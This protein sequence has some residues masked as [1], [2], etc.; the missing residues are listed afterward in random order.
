VY[1]HFPDEESLF[2]ACSS[3]WI[4]RQRP[5]DPD[6]WAAYDEP[7]ARLSAGLA[8]IYRYYGDGEQMLAL[9]RRD[10]DSVPPGVRA[11]RVQAQENWVRTLLQPF[12]GRRRRV[13]R[14]AMAHATTFETWRSLRRD[15]GLSDSSVVALMVGMIMSVTG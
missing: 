13:L 10:A 12:P 7:M 6:R 2:L 15:Q 14:A 9:V 4:S 3:Q 8:D 1:R 11:A 5:P